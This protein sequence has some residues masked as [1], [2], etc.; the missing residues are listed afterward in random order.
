MRI[1][2]TIRTSTGARIDTRASAKLRQRIFKQNLR[3]LTTDARL[4]RLDPR[5]PI[6]PSTHG[7]P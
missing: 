5:A 4:C 6:N 2:T 3:R 7:H 1:G